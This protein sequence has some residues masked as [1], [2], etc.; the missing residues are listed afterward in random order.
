M[1]SIKSLIGNIRKPALVGTPLVINDYE[2]NQKLILLIPLKSTIAITIITALIV[3]Q[4]L[5]STLTAIQIISDAASV[6]A[7][8][9]D[10]NLNSVQHLRSQTSKNDYCLN[11]QNLILFY[12]LPFYPSTYVA[13]QKLTNLATGILPTESIYYT[14]LNI[15]IADSRA[16]PDSATLSL[17][18][19]YEY[20][21]RT[22]PGFLLSLILNTKVLLQK[23][24]APLLIYL[25]IPRLVDSLTRLYDQYRY[26]VVP[27]PIILV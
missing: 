12:R 10:T 20:K 16:I 21:L 15:K 23:I 2:L 24:Y 17:I 25:I 13:L 9:V 26:S 22:R 19:R 3:A 18:L 27:L 8:L 7:L 11:R 4:C 6:Y 5:P 14:C 1:L